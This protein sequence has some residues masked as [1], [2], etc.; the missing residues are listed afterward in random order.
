MADVLWGLLVGAVIVGILVFLD[1]WTDRA[2]AETDKRAVRMGLF[3][4]F[5][6]FGFLI[7]VWGL[8]STLQAYNAGDGA[9]VRALT[10]VGLG[11]AAALT[12]IP[13]PRRVLARLIPFN[14]RDYKDIVGLLLILWIV[15]FQV[16]QYFLPDEAE[17]SVT[18]G[19][20][21]VQ[22][23]TL[24]AIAYVAVGG[25]GRRSRSEVLERLGVERP[26]ARQVGIA[27]RLVVVIL[28]VSVAANYLA[29]VLVPGVYED[30]EETLEETTA[31]LDLVWGAI[32]IALTAA[33]GE[34]LLFRG[35]I[36]P[37]YGV[38]FTSIVFALVHVQYHPAL[39]LTGLL[40]VGLVLG[41][42]RK[43][44]NTTACIFTHAAYNLIAVL[45]S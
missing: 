16:G 38:I 44:L 12:L 2:N 42:E 20:L 41:Y 37:R 21:I 15:S 13:G 39:I 45:L 40:P 18:Y 29:E 1:R 28:V 33:I 8:A 3:I 17:V 36:Q 30:L 7:L 27:L 14:P 31:G 35:A 10:F 19:G 34:E 25:F 4:T 24:S 43:Y 23:L 9:D 22:A 5:G 6:A 26:T 32:A 11:L